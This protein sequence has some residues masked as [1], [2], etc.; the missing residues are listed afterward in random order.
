MRWRERWWG[1]ADAKGGSESKSL[2]LRELKGLWKAGIPHRRVEKNLSPTF[3]HRERDHVRG[4]DLGK[5]QGRLTPY[6]VE[7]PN[8]AMCTGTRKKHAQLAFGNV[9]KRP[10]AASATTRKKET[11]RECGRKEERKR[12]NR[13]VRKRAFLARRTPNSDPQAT[14]TEKEDTRQKPCCLMTISYGG[15]RGGMRKRA[16]DERTT[17]GS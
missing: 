10:A 13:P 14:A 2:I 12:T 1:L 15:G 7:K 17:K 16:R 5:F 6:F 9:V 3:Y 11:R 8:R 4:P